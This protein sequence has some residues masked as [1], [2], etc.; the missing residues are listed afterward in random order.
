MGIE[1]EGVVFAAVSTARTPPIIAERSA[2]H[3]TKVPCFRSLM[4]FSR[5]LLVIL[6][7]FFGS[8]GFAVKG[9]QILGWKR[10]YARLHPK[11]WVSTTE[12]PKE[13]FF[14]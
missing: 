10:A 11:I 2:T 13:R 1:V 8:S 12:I 14:Y 9:C 7:F 6:V 5:F 4:I 3:P